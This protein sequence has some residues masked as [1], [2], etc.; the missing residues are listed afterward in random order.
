MPVKTIQASYR[1]TGYSL[2]CDGS[3]FDQ[4]C[5]PLQYILKKAGQT[6]TPTDE[7]EKEYEIPD[8][9]VISGDEEDSIDIF[10]TSSPGDVPIPDT[11]S[12]ANKCG[13][14][15]ARKNLILV[16]NQNNNE[17]TAKKPKKVF[18]CSDCGKIY[19]TYYGKAAKEH[20]SE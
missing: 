12:A 2:K 13:I 7:N 20:D 9:F 8:P 15:S 5:A 1:V 3:E 17:V 6:I 18:K 4:L 14:D 11:Q 16:T 19:Q 10:S